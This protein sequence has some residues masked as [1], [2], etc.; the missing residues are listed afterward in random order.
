MDFDKVDRLC[1]EATTMGVTPGLVVLAA[2]EG[3]LR[4]LAAWG[5]SQ[6]VPAAV[7]VSV[8]TVFDI[9]SV[10]KAVATSV[11]TMQLIGRGAL[12]LDS[13]VATWLPEFAGSP[14]RDVV[15]LRHLLSH[16]AGLPA[17]RP[18]HEGAAALYEKAT[19][20]A[21]GP[22]RVPGI[23]S[24]RFVEEAATREPLVYPPG[25]RSLYTDLGFIVLGRI[26]ER[27]AQA[28]LDV[29]LATTIVHPLGLVK[30]RYVPAGN[31]R[32]AG[33]PWPDR[34]TVAATED[35]PVRGSVVVGEVHDLNAYAMGGIAGHAGLFSTAA[36]L[37][38]M[39]EAL[40]LD[41]QGAR[42]PSLV[43]RDVIREFWRPA[44]IPD[45]TWRLG[46][47]GPAPHGSQAGDRLSRLA[48]GHLGFTGCSLWIDPERA[49]WIVVLANRI[50]PVVTPSA[51]YRAFRAA[52]HDAI[53]EA[54]SSGKG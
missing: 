1:H 4:L 36:E 46:W 45:S 17:H 32:V 35:C 48:V 49:R 51:R 33:A 5:A 20:G 53:V 44:G 15:S 2:D 16:S 38:K 24:R 30:T 28:G 31:G 21:G 42:T 14:D 12:A 47:D 11:L 52:L 3:R 9:A 10:T 29:Q 54:F 43:P 6:V 25:T 39:A 50:H 19:Y 34:E 26:L 23:A 22:D 37:G 7:A 40:V 8:E 27:V 41:W 13:S 18:F